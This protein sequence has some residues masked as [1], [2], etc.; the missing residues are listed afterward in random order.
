MQME[1]T[2]TMTVRADSDGQIRRAFLAW[3]G[4]TAD[5]AISDGS[6]FAGD[7]RLNT[8]G[9]IR[10]KLLATEDAVTVSEIY[11]MVGV[12]IETV[13]GLQVSNNDGNVST[14]EVTF[15]SVYWEIENGSVAKGAFP[16][17]K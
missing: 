6:V 2:H 1:Q 9:V 17:Q 8:A 12:K 16:N 7:R 3:A 4:K 10:I 11:K 15:R 14:F 13:G 5:P